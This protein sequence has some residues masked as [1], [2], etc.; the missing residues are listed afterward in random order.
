[1]NAPG[2]TPGQAGRSIAVRAMT[3]ASLLPAVVLAGTALLLLTGTIPAASSMA[4]LTVPVIAIDALAL[5]IGLWR[6]KVWVYWLA[7]AA[8]AIAAVLPG[9]P[10][11]QVGGAFFALAVL[12][13]TRPRY[14][15]A[16]G[17]WPVI[18]AAALLALGTVAAMGGLVLPAAA[19]VLAACMLL[20]RPAP[21]PRREDQR[22]D[23]RAVLA[24]IGLGGLQPYRL[25]PPATAVAD[26]AGRAAFSFA[27]AGRSAVVL[28][29]PSGDPGP[30]WQVFDAW[31]VQARRLDWSP[32]VYQ[33]SEAT[34][35]RLES[36]GWHSVLVGMEAV[37]D[38][39][40]FR[41]GSP[42]VANVRHTVTR[43][44]KGGVTVAWSAT[45]FRGLPEGLDLRDGMTAVDDAWRRTAG[46][47]MGF[48][49]GQFDPDRIDDAAI[50]AALAADGTVLAFVVLRP[51]GADG[52]WMLDLI[53]RVPG[54]VPGAV[55]ACLVAAIVGLGTLGVRRLSLGL[56]P[57]H[58]L[59]PGTGPLAQRLLARGARLVRP[60]YDYP[61]L[62]FF[63]GKFDPEWLPRYLLV[64]SRAELL[65][66]SL[67][68]L[69]LHLGGSWTATI[70]SIGGRVPR[71]AIRSGAARG[72]ATEVGRALVPA[73]VHGFG[74]AERPPAERYAHVGDGQNEEP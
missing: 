66:A 7:I 44:R 72:A 3:A 46:T 56:A 60:F 54:S 58:G 70:R 39:T 45:G 50:A 53:R 31:T 61:G 4:W 17:R 18:A 40:A 14:G 23:A 19:A 71:D 26:D 25:L 15:A 47:A 49:V 64:Q 33:A 68:L 24:G 1:M 22:T 41:L 67:A 13:A 42:R 73:P 59:D 6:R 8:F 51:T 20:L 63:K 37:V 32:V 34:R 5:A 57:L 69:R 10:V 36:L 12:V 30:A 52:S 29:D 65:P 43:S 62:A 2:R 55:E 28:G 9:A 16:T 38:P 35:R 21:D 27:R 48:T 74:E 11:A